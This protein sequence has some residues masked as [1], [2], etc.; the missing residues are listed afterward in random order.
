MEA[1]QADHL[2]RSFTTK[3][4]KSTKGLK[5]VIQEALERPAD[6][7]IEEMVTVLAIPTLVG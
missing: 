4:A 2:V 1:G 7:V 5:S 6:S 3:D